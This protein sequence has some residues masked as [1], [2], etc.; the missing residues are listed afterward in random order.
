MIMNNKAHVMLS[1]LLLGIL[2]LLVFIVVQINTSGV[3]CSSNM[4]GMMLGNMSK[5]CPAGGCSGCRAVTCDNVVPICNTFGSDSS[6]CQRIIESC[7]YCAANCCP[8]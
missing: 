4:S 2:A 8:D 3:K 1:I 5:H 6:Q 7:S